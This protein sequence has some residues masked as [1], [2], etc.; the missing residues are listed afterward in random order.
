M[1]DHRYYRNKVKDHLAKFD[2]TDEE[3]QKR[4]VLDLRE[5]VAQDSVERAEKAE[6]ALH[7]L[8]KAVRWALTKEPSAYSMSVLSAALVKAKE[9]LGD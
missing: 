9:T 4:L 7:D 6:A 8:A 2:E 1:P 5:E 3:F